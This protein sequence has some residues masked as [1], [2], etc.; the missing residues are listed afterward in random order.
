MTLT[1]GLDEHDHLI[2]GVVRDVPPINLDHLVAFIKAGHAQIS[3]KRWKEKE[4]K[5]PLASVYLDVRLKNAAS[6]Y[7]TSFKRRDRIVCE[8]AAVS[9]TFLEPLA[10]QL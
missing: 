4:K 3:L 2:M 7:S 9:P 10:K 8:V 6:P 5:R 1:A